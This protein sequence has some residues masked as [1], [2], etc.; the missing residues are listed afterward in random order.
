MADPEIG[1]A[2][3]AEGL[4]PGVAMELDLQVRAGLFR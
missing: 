2:V 1:A 4:R 3:M